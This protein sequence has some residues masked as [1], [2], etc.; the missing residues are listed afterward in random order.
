M[1]KKNQKAKKNRFDNTSVK[2]RGFISAQH[3]TICLC[4]EKIV[5]GED[6]E[7]ILGILEDDDEVEE[8]FSVAVRNAQRQEIVCHD[9]GKKY[10]T[11]GGYHRHRATKHNNQQ[12]GLEQVQQLS[13]S[14]LA[15]IIDRAIRSV[16]ERK[17]FAENLRKELSNYLYQQ[18]QKDSNE[19]S[20]I[21]AIYEGYTRNGDAEKFYG[22]Y[23]ATVAVKS[24][25]FFSGLSRNAATLLAT[26]VADCLLTYS[27]QQKHSTES[28][29]NIKTVLSDKE[30]AGMQ[31]LEGYV[32]QNLHKKHG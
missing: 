16:K 29:H 10:K 20:A 6:F 25:Q 9:C 32:L 5:W 3:I 17:V 30:K 11:I 2:K 26:K 31:Y 27:K 21:K 4:G 15:E 7:A 12:E 19:F 13:L 1:K 24:T 8:Q 22:K 14:V 23:Y 28:S 18:L